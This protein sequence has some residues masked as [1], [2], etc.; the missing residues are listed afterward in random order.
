MIICRIKLGVFGQGAM[1]NMLLNGKKD[2][3]LG[4]NAL[5]NGLILPL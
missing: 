5:K 1:K 2:N 4:K 3:P